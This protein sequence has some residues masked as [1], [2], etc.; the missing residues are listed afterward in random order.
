MKQ[1]SSRRRLWYHGE[2]EE[3]DLSRSDV[4]WLSLWTALSNN[5]RT[6]QSKRQG[7]NKSSKIMSCQMTLAAILTESNIE[8]SSRIGIVER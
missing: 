2:C 6:I 4:R 1:V 7:A 5:V 3:M 8:Q